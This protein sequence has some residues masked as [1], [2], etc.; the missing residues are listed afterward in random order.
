[1]KAIIT[2]GG[3][4]ET[5]PSHPYLM[6]KQNK[7]KEGERWH[8]NCAR[9]MWVNA[10]CVFWKQVEKDKELSH[11]SVLRVSVITI[12]PRDGEPAQTPVGWDSH[13]CV[14]R[15]GWNR[16]GWEGGG[17]RRPAHLGCTSFSVPKV[18]PKAVPLSS[19]CQEAN[20]RPRYSKGG[21]V[22]PLPTASSSSL[23]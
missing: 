21:R 9:W 3:S 15:W 2:G 7:A 17:S 16:A 4:E 1:M 22:C 13:S 14:R 5:I 20:P 11:A 10:L 18:S 19:S 23:R 6:L 12:S 8:P